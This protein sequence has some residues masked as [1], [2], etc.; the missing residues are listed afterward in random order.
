M[1][2]PRH[3]RL[4]VDIVADAAT[5]RDR[6]N[7]ALGF[8]FGEN[9]LPGAH[10]RGVQRPKV[11]AALFYLATFPGFMVPGPTTSR[12][13]CAKGRRRKTARAWTRPSSCGWASP[14]PSCAHVRGTGRGAS[15]GSRAACPALPD[16]DALPVAGGGCPSALGAESK[17]KVEK[18]RPGPS[19]RVTKKK[20]RDAARDA[21]LVVSVEGGRSAA[22]RGA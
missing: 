3:L 14:S 19:V 5:Y 6:I 9:F 20:P 15:A 17:K 16:L 18:A 8:W 13:S 12:A 2:L 7:S 4:P 22:E 21:G 11:V 10:H 1:N